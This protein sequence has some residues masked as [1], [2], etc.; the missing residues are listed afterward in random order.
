M[1]A[2]SIDARILVYA[3]ETGHGKQEA[4]L[5]IIAATARAGGLITVQA[6]GE[7]FAATTR[8]RK[9]EPA[10]AMR[11]VGFWRS[12][13]GKPLAHDADCLAAAMAACGAGRFSFWDAMLLATAEAAGC[14]TIISGDMSPGATLGRI[15]VIPAFEGDAISPQAAALRA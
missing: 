9:L 2:L 4:A 15:R 12:A 3:I 5:A 6:L 1:T 7:F 14:T 8:K 10:A 13:F 11:Q